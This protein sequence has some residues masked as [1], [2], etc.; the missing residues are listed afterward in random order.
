[1]NAARGSVVDEDALIAAPS[2]GRL[3][4]TA[5]HVFASEPDPDPRLTSWPNFT[6]SPQ[7]SGTVE[8]HDAMAGLILD[9]IEATFNGRPLMSEAPS[10]SGTEAAQN[11]YERSDLFRSS[12]YCQQTC[13]NV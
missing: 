12:S 6:P 9:D 4:G 1:M 11:W 2:G 10:K 7:A 8:T 13:G 3:G 5:L